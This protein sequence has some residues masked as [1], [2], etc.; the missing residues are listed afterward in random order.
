MEYY[1]PEGK[2]TLN[3]EPYVNF[4]KRL[5]HT[6]SDRLSAKFLLL[7]GGTDFG[8]KPHR[9][10]AEFLDY[11]IFQKTERPVIAICRG[12]QLILKQDGGI[13]VPHLPDETTKLQHTTLTGNWKGMSSWHMTKAGLFT[14]TRHH[15]GYFETPDGWNLLDSTDDGVV[16]AVKKQNIFGVQWHPELL[17]MD[18]TAAQDWFIWQMEQTIK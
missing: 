5:G 15:Q 10:D 12:M 7:P 1:L 18:G 13:L 16:E 4:M 2:W 9:D 6:Q 3:K 8:I 17:E 14:N 11:E